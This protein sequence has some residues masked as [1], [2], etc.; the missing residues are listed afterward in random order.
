MVLRHMIVHTLVFIATTNGYLLL[1]MITVNPRVWGHRDYP[2]VVRSKVSAQ[3][4]REKLAAAAIGLPWIIFVFGFPLF[5]TFELRSLLDGE[6]PFLLAFLHPLILMEMSGVV[7][8]VVLDWLIVSKLTPGFVRISG[9]AE[10]DYKDMS[11]H[12]RGHLRAAVVFV[13]ISLIIGT[14]VILA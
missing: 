1:M 7:E 12:Y 14:V 3:T 6:I 13:P 8:V 9:T 2:E 4:K 11:H 5:S 10:E